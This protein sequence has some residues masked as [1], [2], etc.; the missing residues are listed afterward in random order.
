AAYLQDTVAA[1][2]ADDSAELLHEIHAALA[3]LRLEYRTVFVLFHEQGR[4]YEEIAQALERPVGTIKTWLHRARLE[5]LERLRQ[6]GMVAPN[7]ETAHVGVDD[8]RERG[9]GEA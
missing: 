5:I 1:P 2:A 7:E 8:R 3:E 4:P 9:G 6:R